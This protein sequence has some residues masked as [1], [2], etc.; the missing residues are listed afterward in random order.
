MHPNVVMLAYRHYENCVEKLLSRALE[1]AA[2]DCP[3]GTAESNV[4]KEAHITGDLMIVVAAV[5]FDG[6]IMN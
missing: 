5:S 2:R 3:L 1:V 4:E 6:D